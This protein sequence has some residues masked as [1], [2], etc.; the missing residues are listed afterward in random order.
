MRYYKKR[1][2]IKQVVWVIVILLVYFN[3]NFV[4]TYIVDNEGYTAED[5]KEK[6]TD[7]KESLTQVVEETF[8]YDEP[9][10]K[11]EYNIQLIEQEILHLTN[12]ER[13][14]E[15]LTLLKHHDPVSYAARKHSEW[16]MATYNEP[17]S[18]SDNILIFHEGKDGTEPVDRLNND[19]IYDFD[20]SAEN[21][22]S[23]TSFEFYSPGEIPDS[24]KDEK[25]IAKNMVN[26]WM[27]SPGHRENILTPEL[28]EIGVG[29][30]ID[31]KNLLF[32]GTQNFI[33]MV[34]CGYETGPCCEEEGYYPSCYI[35]L[36]CTNNIC[37]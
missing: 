32:I 10:V 28:E 21:V 26:G 31:S 17:F 34:E 13:K 8:I 30:A 36:D 7:K 22:G 19:N 16:L 33:R 20:M 27:N 3:W 14:K 37:E 1:K 2:L 25:E 9:A 24:E 11:Y 23:A 29:I 15:G 4:T 6:Y 12:K 18:P 35:P 5:L